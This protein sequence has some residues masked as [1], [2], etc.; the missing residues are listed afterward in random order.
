MK[1]IEEN[2]K[3]NKQSGSTTPGEIISV[4]KVSNGKSF[5]SNL[6]LFRGNWLRHYHGVNFTNSFENFGIT[7]I[8]PKYTFI[9]DWQIP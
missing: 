8:N 1:T 9:V 7:T 6:N 3:I 5:F 4:S 2:F